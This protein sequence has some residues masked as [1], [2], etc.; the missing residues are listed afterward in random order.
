MSAVYLC[1]S[2][3]FTNPLWALRVLDQRAN[4]YRAFMKFQGLSSAFH[5]YAL[6]LSQ[7]RRE[8]CF[9]NPYFEDEATE[10]WWNPRG[11]SPGKPGEIFF[12]APAF[13]MLRLLTLLG[14]LCG[15][16]RT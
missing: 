4:L 7:Q 9:P 2:G 5:I 6:P 14:L 8:A 3:K 12:F 1:N 16:L 11:L 15:L 13:L 10:A